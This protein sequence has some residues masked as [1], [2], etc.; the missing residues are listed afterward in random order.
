MRAHAWLG[1]VVLA[2]A[3]SGLRPPERAP[4]PGSSAPVATPATVTSSAPVAPTHGEAEDAGGPATSRAEALPP[5][6]AV[7]PSV[8]PV[9]TLLALPGSATTSVGGPSGGQLI[10]GLPLPDVGPGFVHNHERPDAARFGS[11]ELVQL[12]MRA[13]AAVEQE[14]PGSVLTVNDLSLEHGGPIAQHGSHQN[15]R[16]ADIL[17]Y[18]LDEHRAP[19]ASVGVP[20]D[21]KGQ[22]WDFKDLAVADDDQRV[23]LDA[24]RTWR[25]V[26][27]MLELAPE[28]VQ[29]IFMVEHVRT[30]LLAQAD[31][32]H[33]PRLVRERFADITCQPDAPHDDHLHLRLYCTPEDLAAGCLDSPPTYPWRSALLRVAGLSPSIAPAY[34]TGQRQAAS[35]RKTTP[36]QARAKAGPMHARVLHF[37]AE[38]KGWLEQPHPGR[39]YCK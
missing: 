15:G 22:G 32:V 21:P 31:K 26:Q 36:A 23:Q 30:L 3:C 34:T 9:T 7:T 17:Y 29:R 28:A 38:R 6:A 25:F 37:L 35:K 27:A 1:V 4:A 19:I 39:A 33:A 8:D 24:P 20:L 11:V 12:I 16:D 2:L 14:A 5:T 13:A 18:V 10:G